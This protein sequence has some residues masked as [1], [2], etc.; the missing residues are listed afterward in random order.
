MSG[1]SS[2]KGKVNHQPGIKTINGKPTNQV[3]LVLDLIQ[4]MLNHQPGI[5]KNWTDR[6]PDTFD[7]PWK[8][9]NKKGKSMYH[10]VMT[11]IAMENHHF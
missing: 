4:N 11:S 2:K 1:E 10:L 9:H 5:K 3:L 7:L 6:F 8:K